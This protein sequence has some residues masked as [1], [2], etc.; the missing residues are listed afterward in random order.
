MNHS[1]MLKISYDIIKRLNR[2]L[3]ENYRCMVNMD[4]IHTK[5]LGIDRIIRNLKL[6][7]V[8]IIV[9]LRV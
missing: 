2:N 1:L 4:K 8:D 7:V 3:Y 6:N 5:Q 9:Y